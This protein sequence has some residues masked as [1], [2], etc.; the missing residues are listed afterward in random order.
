MED[1]WAGKAYAHGSEKVGL[2]IAVCDRHASASLRCVDEINYHPR[3]AIFLVQR[4]VSVAVCTPRSSALS[5]GMCLAQS[6]P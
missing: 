4:A 1:N 2:S 6:T 3:R 5:S